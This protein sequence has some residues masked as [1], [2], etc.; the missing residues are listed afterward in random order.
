MKNFKLF[1]FITLLFIAFS[2]EEYTEGIND[3]P[4]AFTVASSDLLIGQVQLSYMQHMGSNNARYTSVFT[5]QF[6]GGDRQY[7][8]LNTYSPNRGNY[9][10]M[11]F[12][13]YISG[14]NNARIILEDENAGELVKGVA[15]IIRGTLFADM[16]LLYGDIPYSQASNADEFPEPIYDSQATVIDAS[17]NLIQ[18]GISKVGDASITAGFGGNR[19]SG[20]TW[21]E[22]A[23]TLAAR[24]SISTGNYSSAISF[25]NQ[26]I[27]SRANDL[28]TLHGTSQE[29]RNLYYQ[30]IIDERQD[31][32]VATD[33]YLVQLLDG[34]VA[35]SLN[36]PG[37][38]IRFDH[39]F[40]N[41]G[42]RTLINTE[43]GGRFS[44]T[45]SFPLA[46]YYE[47][48]LI[49]AEAKFKTND[50]D[51]AR[52]HLNNVRAELRN[53]FSSD[54][55]GFPDS[56]ATGDM[57]LKQ[58]LEEKFITLVGE[59]VTFHDLRRTRNFLGVPNKTTG[60]VGASDFPQRF[61]YPQSE[62]DTNPNVPSPLP[63]FFNTT[64]LL[65]SS[66]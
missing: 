25:A 34:R 63:E 41:D 28:V 13:T 52:E 35:R 59:I 33:S 2:C 18:S 61:L 16:A 51:G 17:L 66:Y 23:N 8:T 58:I 57:L 46:S 42:S 14:I 43:N 60:S 53:Q 65:G 29:N 26:G 36:T 48:Q 45:S 56:N 5:N 47:N 10:D 22:A 50:E 20:S 40:I 12:D 19:L 62:V 7:L 6:T 54:A 31:Y 37:D 64:Q 30:F 21:K 49:L 11:W 24:Y 9:N 3:D 39:Y 44:Q 32:L 27:S 15:E 38:S 55:N 4:N 1:T